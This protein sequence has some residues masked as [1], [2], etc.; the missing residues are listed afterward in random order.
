MAEEKGSEVLLFSEDG[1]VSFGAASLRIYAP[2]GKGETNEAGLSV[3]ATC[4][5]FDVL[6]TGDMGETVEKRLVRYGDLPDIELLVVG[7]HGSKYS[8]GEE[9]LEATRPEYA[10]ISVGYN[11]YGHPAEETLE[12]LAAA[13]CAVYRTDQMGTVSVRVTMGG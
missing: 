6:I 9:L 5:S 7:H 10:A 12:R 13:G 2:L 11:T 4:G 1:S 3:L 8:T